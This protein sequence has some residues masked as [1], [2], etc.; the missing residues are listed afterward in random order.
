MR[1]ERTMIKPL[2]P[3]LCEPLPDRR[4]RSGRMGERGSGCGN[5]GGHPLIIRF[6]RAAGWGAD[7]RFRLVPS[8]N[9][10]PSA[11]SPRHSPGPCAAFPTSGYSAH[12]PPS[13]FF[14]IIPAF[15]VE[16]TLGV[17]STTQLRGTVGCA[18]SRKQL[19]TRTLSCV[20]QLPRA[21]HRP[22]DAP[23]AA[24]PPGCTSPH[25]SSCA[26]WL[27]RGAAPAA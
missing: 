18:E 23:Q 4:C 1:V 17:L 10:K 6:S 21:W 19:S 8:R 5:P 14:G 11:S 24:S 9:G 12:S 3:V 15:C 13:R 25:R 2:P 20:R 22:R 16:R 26:A 7:G 27:G